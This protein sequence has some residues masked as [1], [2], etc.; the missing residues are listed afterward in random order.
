MVQGIAEAVQRVR[1]VLQRQPQRGLQ[2]DTPATAHWQHGLRVVSR[3]PNG[4]QVL[5]DMP[6]EIGGSGDQMTPGWLF[7]AGAASCLATCIAMNAAAEGIVLTRLEVSVHSRTDTRGFLGM[8]DGNG[9]RVSA[10]P[11]DMEWRIRI[12][13]QGVTSGRLRELVERSR[14]C[15]PI[16]CVVEGT[17]STHVHIDANII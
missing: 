1:A 7:R 16:A 2:D 11:C 5:T 10:G 12:D 3:H 8:V 4:A 9:E 15:S 6:A 14:R 13:A 17:L